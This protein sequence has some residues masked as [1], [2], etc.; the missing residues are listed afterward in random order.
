MG[1]VD[2]GRL[3]FLDESGLDTRPTRAYA[4]APRGRPAVR[5]AASPAATGGG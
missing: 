4:R 5:S 1:A 3:V 2:P